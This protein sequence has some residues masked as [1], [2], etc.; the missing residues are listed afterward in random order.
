MIE[1]T[2]IPPISLQN[3]RIAAIIPCHNEELTIAKVVSQFQTFLPEAA[4]YV[5][6]NRSSDDTVTEALKAGAIVRQEAQ[7]GKGNVV[8]RMFADIEADIYILI[9]GD[10]TYEIAAVR[11]LIERM[12][13]EQ[14]DMVVGARREAVK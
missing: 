1:M 9:D 4:I 7:P 14:L 13:G 2:A 12:L 3:Y 10:D 6:N 5:Y 11:R 8:R